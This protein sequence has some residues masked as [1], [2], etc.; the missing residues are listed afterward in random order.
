[1]HVS[2]AGHSRLAIAALT[3]VLLFGCATSQTPQEKLAAAYARSIPEAAV[4]T[5]DAVRT[6]TPIDTTKPEIT[7]AHVQPYPTVDAS[8]ALWI[9]LPDELRALCKDKPDELLAVQMA[10]GLPPDPTDNKIFTFTI[11]P[12]DLFRPCASGPQTTTTSCSLDVPP[13]GSARND[14]FVLSQM[15]GSYRVGF[16]SPGYPFTGMGWSYDWDP[17]SATHQ[18]VSEYVT[19]PGS[20][21]SDVTQM[22]AAS[23]CEAKR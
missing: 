12:N 14:N 13:A 21:I 7:V 15:M 22:T 5:P 2:T 20:A 10:L 17:D 4:K 18:G 8:R 23:F 11:N 1:M 16:P 6:L 19:N 3:A 9:S